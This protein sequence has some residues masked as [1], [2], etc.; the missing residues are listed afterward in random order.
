MLQIAKGLQIR[1]EEAHQSSDSRLTTLGMGLDPA[2]GGE[3]HEDAGGEQAEA[4]AER[5][6]DP[7]DL[8]AALEQAVVEDAED[9]DEHGGL[10]EEGGAAAR[11]D[12]Q[13]VKQMRAE[14]L[15]GPASCLGAGQEVK[16]GWGCGGGSFC[17]FRLELDGCGVGVKFV[18]HKRTLVLLQ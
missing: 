6:D 12:H 3:V 9:E 7:G 5:A 11:G 15:W 18:K 4:Y 10:G 17:R 8:D 2:M 14:A 16:A 1:V 13:Q